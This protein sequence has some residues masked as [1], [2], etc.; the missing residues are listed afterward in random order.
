MTK[1]KFFKIGIILCAISV[2]L[3]AFSAHLLKDILSNSSLTSFKTGVRYQFLHGL[4]I[5]I[6]SLNFDKFKIKIL[7]RSLMLFL[8]GIILFS[9]SIYVLSIQTILDINLN[10][11]GP[12]TP[13]GG[14][15]LISAW[16]N[17]LFSI[18]KKNNN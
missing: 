8:I 1:E 11:L 12:M 13:I 4:I 7:V 2:V 15:I 14:L 9:L 5:I 18:R 16:I 17:L 10:I 6:L 3:G